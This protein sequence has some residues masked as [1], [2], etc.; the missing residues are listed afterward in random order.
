[1]THALFKILT[2]PSDPYV[3]HQVLSFAVSQLPLDGPP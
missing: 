3:I 1:M 2:I